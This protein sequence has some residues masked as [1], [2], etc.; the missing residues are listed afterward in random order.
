MD[1]VNTFKIV[2]LIN[3]LKILT[4]LKCAVYSM[5]C[6]SSVLEVVSA[7]KIYTIVTLVKIVSGLN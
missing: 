2:T 5:M 1:A 6:R 4:F 3:S 7:F